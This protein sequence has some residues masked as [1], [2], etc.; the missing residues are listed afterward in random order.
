MAAGL[1]KLYGIHAQSLALQQQRLQH[2][3]ANIANA[4]TPNYRALIHISE[5]TRPY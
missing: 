1:D 5:P 2:V 4:D 3:A